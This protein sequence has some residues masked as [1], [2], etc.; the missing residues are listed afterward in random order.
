MSE[1]FEKRNFNDVPFQESFNIFGSVDF[2]E[3]KFYYIVYPE[4]KITKENRAKLKELGWKLQRH[5]RTNTEIWL[6]NKKDV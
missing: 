3:E 1:I 6:W 2:V 5:S 4:Q